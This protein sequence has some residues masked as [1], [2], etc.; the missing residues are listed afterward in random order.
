MEHLFKLKKDG[1]T[2]GYERHIQEDLIKGKFIIIEHRTPHSDIW[3][4][5]LEI[6]RSDSQYEGSLGVLSN[7]IDYDE[8]CPFVTKDKHGDNVFADD[9]IKGIICDVSSKQ[10]IGRIVT[11]ENPLSCWMFKYMFEEWIEEEGEKEYLAPA[12]DLQDIELIEDK[13]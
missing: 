2:V 10:L 12:P 13:E 6:C 5:A 4:D 9:L 1:K 11:N 3:F 8:K 7:W